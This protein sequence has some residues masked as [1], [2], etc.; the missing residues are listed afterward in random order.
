MGV[1][2]QAQRF[3]GF[4]ANDNTNRPR[5]AP[6]SG[7]VSPKWLRVSGNTLATKGMPTG[8]AFEELVIADGELSAQDLIE[9]KKLEAYEA[10]D[11]EDYMED[12]PAGS[13]AGQ[14]T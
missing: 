11:E 10:D 1:K 14:S 12:T 9:V 8:M 2:A 4:H 5:T 7:T 6:Y 13:G 3:H